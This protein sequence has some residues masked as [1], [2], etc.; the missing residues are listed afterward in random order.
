MVPCGIQ[1]D[2]YHGIK[3]N[4]GTAALALAIATSEPGNGHVRLMFIKV[5]VLYCVFQH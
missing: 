5:T 4:I 2:P 3:P 1:C